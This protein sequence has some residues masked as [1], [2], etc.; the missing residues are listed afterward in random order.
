MENSPWQ[1]GFVAIYGGSAHFACLQSLYFTVYYCIFDSS[2]KIALRL[3]LEAL[4]SGSQMAL[5][6]PLET[7]FELFWALVA[8]WESTCFIVLSRAQCG[9]VRVLLYFPDPSVRK[10][11]FYRTL[12]TP[13]G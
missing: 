9:Y 8:K 2:G 4:G 13:V 12:P 10:Y 3:P 7:H 6:W 11:V 1:V 5:K